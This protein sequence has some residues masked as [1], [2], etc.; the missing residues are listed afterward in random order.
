M[1]SDEFEHSKDQSVDL[2]SNGIRIHENVGGRATRRIGTEDLERLRADLRRIYVTAELD[3]PTR[4]ENITLL[5]LIEALCKQADYACN[6]R[7][8]HGSWVAGVMRTVA[9]I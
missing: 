9:D 8:G 5:R 7:T 6:I 1:R 2:L 4:A 3:S